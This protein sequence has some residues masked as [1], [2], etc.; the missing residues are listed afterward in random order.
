MQPEA[1]V[2]RTGGGGRNFRPGDRAYQAVGIQSEVTGD[3]DADIVTAHG[4]G[5]GPVIQPA[6][7]IPFAKFDR[8]V[9]EIRDFDRLADLVGEEGSRP[10][11]FP[12][13]EEPF[14]QPPVAADRV[15]DDRRGAQDGG[16]FA[17]V[18]QDFDFGG[19]FGLA[20][21]IERLGKSAVNVL[22]F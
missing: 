3:A 10:A 9:R 20:V 14:M 16:V 11:F 21:K 12:G 18:A 8:H 2:A 15:A 13:D 4:L 7:V 22:E 19:R 5:A 6:K 1:E 17:A